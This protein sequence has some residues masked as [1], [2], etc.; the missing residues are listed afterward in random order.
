MVTAM[1]SAFLVKKEGY[2]PKLRFFLQ[3]FFGR[4]RRPK[5]RYP[6]ITL[7]VGKNTHTAIM[8]FWVPES[9]YWLEWLKSSTRGG[10]TQYNL[11]TYD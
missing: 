9:F 5:R 7:N 1:N 4:I 3:L 6:R 10:L 2:A 8:F 11:N